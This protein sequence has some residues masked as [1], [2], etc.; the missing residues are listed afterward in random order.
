V[1]A[2]DDDAAVLRAASGVGLGCAAAGGGCD[3]PQEM[4]VAR[5]AHPAS[6]QIA[7]RDVAG[8]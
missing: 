1:V 5:R 8:T 2:A 7:R 3:G 4:F 6:E